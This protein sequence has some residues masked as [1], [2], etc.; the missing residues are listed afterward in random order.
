MDI[1]VQDLAAKYGCLLEAC[2]H[3]GEET[4]E[5][6]EDQVAVVSRLKWSQL[7]E[8]MDVFSECLKQPGQDFGIDDE[9]MKDILLETNHKVASTHSCCSECHAT[10]L[11]LSGQKA[12]T[13]ISTSSAEQKAL[14]T[15][16]IETKV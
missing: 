16:G 8:Y 2:G 10:H 7:L 15:K 13:W 4:E 9:L 1:D 5:E 12:L 6:K 11:V 14:T 3:V